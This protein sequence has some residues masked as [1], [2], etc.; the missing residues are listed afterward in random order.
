MFTGLVTDVGSIVAKLATDEGSAFKISTELDT[1]DFDVGESIAVDGVCLTA[2]MV[3]DGTFTVE[4]S[5]ETRRCTT[6]ERRGVGHRVHLERALRADERLGGHF[7]TGHV[8]GTGTLEEMR[9]DGNA[10]RL[11]Y[12]APES[13]SPYLVEK[14]CIAVDGVSLTINGVDGDHFDVAIIPHTAEHTHLVD[15]EP[16]RAVNLEADLLGKYARKFLAGHLP[17]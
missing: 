12:R 4:A 3:D 13:V 15:D 16:P 7:V 10:W 11:E 9:R 8:D 14:G 2:A 17:D 5:P 1:T 6:L